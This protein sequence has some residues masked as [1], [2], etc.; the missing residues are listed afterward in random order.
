M[1]GDLFSFPYAILQT[2]ETKGNAAYIT[3]T[4][5]RPAC[6]GCLSVL[7]LTDAHRVLPGAQ[8]GGNGGL[9]P[10]LRREYVNHRI[11]EDMAVFIKNAVCF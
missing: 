6:T 10:P 8:Y 1:S 11:V 5:P 3:S 4:A 2:E 9:P 7:S